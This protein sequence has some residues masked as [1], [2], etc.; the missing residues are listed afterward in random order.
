MKDNTW[1]GKTGLDWSLL[2]LTKDNRP[3]WL[4][5]LDIPFIS[6]NS[7]II[8]YNVICRLRYDKKHGSHASSYYVKKEKRKIEEE[9]LFESWIRT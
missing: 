1:Q 7:T 4:R 8:F 9:A 5:Y 6:L 3:E 2:T